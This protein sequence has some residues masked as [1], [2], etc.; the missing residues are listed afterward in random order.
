[1]HHTT[2]KPPRFAIHFE[3]EAYK[4]AGNIVGRQAAGASF[5]EAVARARPGKLWC[6]SRNRNQ[7][8]LLAQQM[9]DAGSPRTGVQWVPITAPDA[10]SEPGL[11]YRPDPIIA[12]EA[13]RRLS[14][15]RPDRYSLC[16]VTH[17]TATAVVMDALADLTIAPLESW[18]AI[19]CT[20][21]AVRDSVRSLVEASSEYLRERLGAARLTL[22]QLPL[23]PLGIHCDQF[24]HLPEQRQAS[25]EELGIAPD[26]VTVLFLGR[27]SYHAKANPVSMYLALEQASRGKRVVLVQAG[28]F[29]SEEIEANF[30]GDAAALC[31]SVRFLHV[32][33]RDPKSRNHAWAAADIFTSLSD[34]IQE[35]FGLTP[36]EAMAVG[37]PVVVSDW[38]GYRETV[39][40]G[41]DG[42]RIP[43]VSLARG[44]GLDLADR[45]ALGVDGYD[46]YCGQA[47][48][49]V[50]VSVDAAAEAYRKL[51]CE[52]NTRAQM[53]AAARKRAREFDWA[54]ILPRYFELWL[55]LGERRRSDPRLVPALK[56]RFR[57]DR[58]DP[59]RMFATYPS[60]TIGP[61]MEFRQRAGVSS[62][63]ASARREL[64]SIGF[65]A[66]ILP[67]SDVVEAVLSA[68]GPDVWTPIEQLMAGTPARDFVTCRALAWL[69]KVGV[70][71]WQRAPHH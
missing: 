51:I 43:T 22:P 6:Y 11:L 66:P 25:R 13:W 8:E 24:D 1:M 14:W 59:F 28:W 37:L 17:T 19:I 67:S 48:Q 39:R 30:R 12:V 34:N 61:G 18:D 2:S 26:E 68:T 41:V 46:Q 57:P 65:A 54:T 15:S 56:Q 40:D 31:P 60:D 36:L 53:G 63:L 45:F 70:L 64:G 42:F 35:T 29:G 5:A 55:E 4:Q 21:A 10:L 7:A 58:P 50:A 38:D 62:A 47:S 33:A 16:G 20:S 23:I 27:L 44:N 32:D 9:A 69:S 3:A 49:F 52:P 71:A